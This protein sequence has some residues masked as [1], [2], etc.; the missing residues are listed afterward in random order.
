LSNGDKMLINRSRGR[1]LPI[2]RFDIVAYEVKGQEG[3][4][5]KRVL[6]LPGETLQIREGKVFINGEELPENDYTKSLAYAGTA[7][8]PLTLGSTEFFVIGENADASLDSRFSDVG[9]IPAD[10][11][12]GTI[13][14]RYAPFRDLRFLP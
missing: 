13:W 8:T 11:L 9:N 4:F 7:Q 2:K 1:I 10:Q 14:F 5:L 6:A 3:V 12:L